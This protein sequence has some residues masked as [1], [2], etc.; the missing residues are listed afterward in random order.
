MRRDFYV[1]RWTTA[2]VREREKE[3]GGMNV[4]LNIRALVFETFCVKL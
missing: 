1:G 3:K 4:S 2:C